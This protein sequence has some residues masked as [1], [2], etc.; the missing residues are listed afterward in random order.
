MSDNDTIAGA[1]PPSHSAPEP[2]RLL[3]ELLEGEE[4]RA[5]GWLRGQQ[6]RA[7]MLELRRRDG[8][9]LA[10]GY[11]WLEKAE[12]DP[13]NG[14]VLVVGEATIRVR[15]QN[16]NSELRP[17]VRLYE[18]ITRHR[19]PWIREASQIDILTAQRGETLVERIDWS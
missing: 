16:L 1:K 9:S 15:G 7:I 19:V 2:D 4:R 12:F 18:G 14:I 8:S 10:V 11:N 3:R 13:A 5:F 17:N 6:E